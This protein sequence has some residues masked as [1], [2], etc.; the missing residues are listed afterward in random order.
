MITSVNLTTP[1]CATRIPMKRKQNPSTK[2]YKG[3]SLQKEWLEV[4]FSNLKQSDPDR[5]LLQDYIDDVMT[6]SHPQFTSCRE[7]LRAI[8][9]NWNSYKTRN[10]SKTSTVKITKKSKEMIEQFCEQEEIEVA[11]LF[12]K[13]AELLE[14]NSDAAKLFLRHSSSEV[15]ISIRETPSGGNKDIPKGHTEESILSTS[16]SR[17]TRRF[18][19]STNITPQ[20]PPKKKED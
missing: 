12:T 14:S 7:K 17:K 10:V 5:S 20:S 13:I 15:D 2:W 19:M 3:E 16:K 8:E 11:H 9:G 1:T 4:Q 6:K 18:P